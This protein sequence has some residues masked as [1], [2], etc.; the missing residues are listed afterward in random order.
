MSPSQARRNGVGSHTVASR[1]QMLGSTETLQ[2]WLG[3]N[4]DG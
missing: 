2:A 4:L 1:R 3:R